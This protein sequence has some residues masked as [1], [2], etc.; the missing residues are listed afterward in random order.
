M[1][2]GDMG[3]MMILTLTLETTETQKPALE[4]QEHRLRDI[5]LRQLLIAANTGTFD[6]NYTAEARLAPLRRD[7]LDAVQ[8]ATGPLVAAVLIEDIARQDR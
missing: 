7:L 2:N 1:R 6:G 4:Q 3:A 5:L 8:T